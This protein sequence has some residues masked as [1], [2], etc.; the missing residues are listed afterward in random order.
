[1][2]PP[3]IDEGQMVFFSPD[4]NIPG[5]IQRRLSFMEVPSYARDKIACWSMQ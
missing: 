1:V 3:K 5:S 2:S 4:E